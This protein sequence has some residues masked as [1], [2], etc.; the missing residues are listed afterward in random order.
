[1]TAKTDSAASERSA[2]RRSGR[3]SAR[4][5][6]VERVTRADPVALGED[7]GASLRPSGSA[8]QQRPAT[9]QTVLY[10][11]AA[12]AVA[13]LPFDRRFLTD[14]ITLALGLA[15]V[16]S[17][18]QKGAVDVGRGVE[19]YYFHVEPGHLLH[20]GGRRRRRRAAGQT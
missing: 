12:Y 9:S 5:G 19:R 18:L 10:A 3:G 14:V 2:T 8:R 7:A 1:M 20:P 11:I 13:R 15:A 16:K 4:A 6:T 17:I